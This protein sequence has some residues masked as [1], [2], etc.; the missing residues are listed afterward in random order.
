MPLTSPNVRSYFQLYRNYWIMHSEI[1]LI[2]FFDVSNFPSNRYQLFL[3]S[4]REG[5]I[6]ENAMI[7]N[8]KRGRLEWLDFKFWFSGSE[9]EVDWKF[10]TSENCQ[11]I[12]FGLDLS[13]RVMLLKLFYIAPKSPINPILDGGWFPHHPPNRQFLI[14]IGMFHL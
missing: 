3:I 13:I 14:Q 2:Q 11:K 7:L 8:Y 9:W 1:I 5:V 10:L 4:G 6:W 12:R